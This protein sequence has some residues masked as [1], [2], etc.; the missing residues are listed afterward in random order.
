MLL[1]QTSQLSILA[2]A[3]EVKWDPWPHIVIH[4]AL[5]KDLYAKLLET[6]LD[7][8]Q[9]MLWSSRQPKKM[10]NARYDLAAGMVLKLDYPSLKPWKDFI[11]YHVSGQFWRDILS[12]FGEV[13]RIAHPRFSTDEP[14]GCRYLDHAP[15]LLD[16]QMGINSP[17]GPEP[18]RVVG[19]HIDN[20]QALFAG[21]LYMGEEGGGDLQLYR[22]KKQRVF[23]QEGM[24]HRIPDDAVDLV[25]VIPYAN[26]TFVGFINSPDT[27]HGVSPRQ[28]EQPRLLTNFLVDSARGKI[29]N[30][31]G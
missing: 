14:V 26:N 9:I 21:M 1:M 19:P 16:C 8:E 3:G 4:D 5:P 20:P 11:A 7:W 17:T 22:W 31:Y 12:V 10:P 18:S 23:K 25:S 13:I 27:V 30:K 6:R 2:K 29:F 28:S 24:G 15:I